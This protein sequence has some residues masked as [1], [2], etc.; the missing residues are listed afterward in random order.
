MRFFIVLMSCLSFAYSCGGGNGGSSDVVTDS[1]Q[2][3]ASADTEIRDVEEG[4][5]PIDLPWVAVDQG[6]IS[7]VKSVRGMTCMPGVVYVSADG[8]EGGTYAK[9][10]ALAEPPKEVL[11][12]V[13]LLKATESGV[14][15]STYG[16][17]N[18][19]ASLFLLAGDGT[20]TDQGLAVEQ[21]EVKDLDY[22]NGLVF[23]MSKDWKTAEYLVY[24]GALGM[25]AFEQAGV[26]LN[27]TAMS[28][29]VD[30]DYMY[31]LTI[32]NATLGSACY[33]LATNATAGA[34]W[35]SCPGFPSY[36]QT[37]PSD[38]YSVKAEMF[39]SEGAFG[40]WFRVNNMGV[41]EFHVFSGNAEGFSEVP[42]FPQV[43]PV[44]WHH[45]G[46][47]LLLS[48]AG[49]AS[50]AGVWAAPSHA[51]AQARDLT[52]GLPAA[53]DPKDGMA[54][55]CQTGGRLYGAWFSFNPGGST[56]SLYQKSL[57]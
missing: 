7:G 19:T 15:I 42:G 11:D 56:I 18:Q 57:E 38:P 41:N 51:A 24:R 43:E 22:A 53:S 46:Q 17:P 13:G 16:G 21:T 6:Q 30:G 10:L 52:E 5:E 26:R 12:T 48:Y 2:L 32:L 9:D 33:R 27:E 1:A 23:M 8:T 25:M 44:A 47:E 20:A 31:I 49:G 3:D 55:F 28:Y 36:V 4:P 35:E 37:K 45:T 50:T 40:L 34:A 54:A 14:L 39:A 29:F